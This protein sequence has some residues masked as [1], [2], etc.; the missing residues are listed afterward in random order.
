MYSDESMRRVTQGPIFGQA[1]SAKGIKGMYLKGDCKLNL[2]ISN[3]R[4]IPQEKRYWVEQGTM[5][6]NE[7]QETII[8]IDF[9]SWYN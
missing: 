2:E 6:K 3:A 5:T 8:A 7:L 4:K 9:K 1:N